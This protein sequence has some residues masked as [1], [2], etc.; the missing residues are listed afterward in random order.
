MKIILGKHCSLEKALQLLKKDYKYNV[1]PVLIRHSAYY[2]PSEIRRFKEF[3]SQRKYRRKLYKKIMK[4]VRGDKK[5]L[6]ERIN[7]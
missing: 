1:K 2:K 5:K 7:R 6:R 4:E 3:L